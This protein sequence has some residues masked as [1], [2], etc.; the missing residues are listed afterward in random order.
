[1]LNTSVPLGNGAFGPDAL[2]AKEDHV[3]AV[4]PAIDDNSNFAPAEARYQA[5]VKLETGSF[6]TGYEPSAIN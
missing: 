5:G 3:N 2:V 6:G 1:V 4:V